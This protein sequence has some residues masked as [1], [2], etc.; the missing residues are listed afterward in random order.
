VF[1]GCQRSAGG[2]GWAGGLMILEM[3]N[4]WLIYVN[5]LEMVNDDG[6]Y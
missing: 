2:A 1:N 4:L 3:V 5:I 6:S